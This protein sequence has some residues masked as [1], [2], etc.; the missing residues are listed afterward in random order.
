MYFIFLPAKSIFLSDLYF[1][2]Y[3]AGC[4]G[5]LSFILFF[6]FPCCSVCVPAYLCF[7]RS[8]NFYFSIKRNMTAR[9]VGSS[10]RRGVPLV[11]YLL[12]YAHYPSCPACYM[13]PLLPRM[14]GPH[15]FCPRGYTLPE[16]VCLT[17]IL[18]IMAKTTQSRFCHFFY[19][20]CVRHTHSGSVYPRA[21][22]VRPTHSW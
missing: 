3:V 18:V 4:W 13:R 2:P 22:C 14:C 19:Q 17:H 7:D 5:L 20:M 11:W 12:H 9:C 1:S 16:C 10:H 21:E 15:T 6:S 8:I